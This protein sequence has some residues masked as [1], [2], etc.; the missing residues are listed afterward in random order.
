[1]DSMVNHYTA[2]LRLRSN[3]AYTPGGKAGFSP[4]TPSRSIR[5]SSNGCFRTFGGRRR[6]RSFL[7]RLT[8][9]DYW[10]DTLKPRCWPKAAPTC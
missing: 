6:H 9:Y 10:N 5:K 2:N 3:D 8:H 4:I 7:R 1:M